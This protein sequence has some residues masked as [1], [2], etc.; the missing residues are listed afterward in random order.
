MEHYALGSWEVS[1]SREHTSSLRTWAVPRTARPI[2]MDAERKLVLGVTAG[3][4]AVIMPLDN[5]LRWIGLDQPERLRLLEQ[6]GA[7]RLGGWLGALDSAASAAERQRL[8]KFV[9]GGTVAA[10]VLAAIAGASAWVVLPVEDLLDAPAIAWLAGGC[11]TAAVGLGLGAA[12][13]A[14]KV[15]RMDAIL[16]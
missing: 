1:S 15:R 6:L 2:V 3:D 9:R 7:D 4:G 13:L 14:V 16:S 12:I 5:Q 10:L 8:R 11:G